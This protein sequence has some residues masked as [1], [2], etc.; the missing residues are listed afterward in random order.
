MLRSFVTNWCMIASLVKL[1]TWWIVRHVEVLLCSGIGMQCDAFSDT[2]KCQS[3]S[4]CVHVDQVLS[5][6]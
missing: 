1:K 4:E 2:L 6:M 5:Y 3:T